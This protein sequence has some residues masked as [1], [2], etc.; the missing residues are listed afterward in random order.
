MSRRE[1]PLR[2]RPLSG[3]VLFLSLALALVAVAPVHPVAAQRAAEVERIDAG[4]R[5]PNILRSELEGA[6]VY[7][8]MGRH[9]GTVI[10]VRTSGD[11]HLAS[12]RMV[13]GGFLGFGETVVTL[14]AKNLDVVRLADRPAVVYVPMTG[15][16]LEA[17]GH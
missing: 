2:L 1:E 5:A 17:L 8:S 6:R 15:T 11:G 12:A 10:G 9:V 13:V 4:R 3:V 16:E 14:D 7:D